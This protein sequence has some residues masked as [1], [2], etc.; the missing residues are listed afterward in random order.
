MYIPIYIHTYLSIFIYYRRRPPDILK[1]TKV[2]YL[3]A[4]EN[5]DMVPYRQYEFHSFP[6][7]WSM[8]RYRSRYNNN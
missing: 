3:R 8:V 6:R 1:A 4:G 5:R 2:V 7:G